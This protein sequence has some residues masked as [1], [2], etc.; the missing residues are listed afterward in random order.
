MGTLELKNIVRETK[1]S[2]DWINSRM[3][4][5]EGESLNLKI[6]QWKLSNLNNKEKK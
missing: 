2:L 4:V 3:E 5:A 6:N 1:I